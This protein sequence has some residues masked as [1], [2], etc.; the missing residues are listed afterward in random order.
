VH[1]VLRQVSYDY[2]RMQYN[3][4]VSGAMK[5]LNALEGFKG[6]ATRPMPGAARGLRHPAARAVPG[7]PAHHLPA[8]ARAGLRRHAGRPA[9][10]ALAAVDEA[11][12]CSATRSN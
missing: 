4:V 6:Q 10:R 8:V 9:R 3:T 11:A 5:M 7:L 1:T 2:E 12:H